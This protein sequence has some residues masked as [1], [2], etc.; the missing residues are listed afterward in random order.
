MQASRP[1][2]RV[3]TKQSF[4][5]VEWR[6]TVPW[7]GY[8]STRRDP[9]LCCT[10]LRSLDCP[11]PK[12]FWKSSPPSNVRKRHAPC[13]TQAPATP[14]QR[15]GDCHETA[16]VF[17]SVF[18]VCNHLKFMLK[19]RMHSIAWNPAAERR[20]SLRGTLLT[21]VP[22]A[23]ASSLLLTTDPPESVP[24]LHLIR[25]SA[26]RP[27]YSPLPLGSGHLTNSV[28]LNHRTTWRTNVG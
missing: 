1:P 17:P 28:G 21:P 12:Y 13:P 22:V 3:D 20:V 4:G 5:R 14:R 19:A 9:R 18:K 23:L 8:K 26:D 27:W 7:S 10:P 6:Q 16:S 24:S 11:P 15:P 2:G 25:R